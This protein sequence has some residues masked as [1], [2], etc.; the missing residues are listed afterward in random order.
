[1][2][3]LELNDIVGYLL[4]DMNVA[5]GDGGTMTTSIDDARH[6][7]RRSVEY[8]ESNIWKPALHPLSEY[9]HKMIAGHVM[10]IL[11][12]DLKTIREIWELYDG[13]KKLENISLKTYNVM[14]K[15]HIDFNGLIDDGLAIDINTLK[16]K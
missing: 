3:K 2:R 11:N 16:G 8:P 13:T 6:I 9:C 14:C 12:C 10:S 7:I 15:N 4:H 5:W 1:M